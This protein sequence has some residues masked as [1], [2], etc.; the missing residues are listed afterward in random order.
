MRV[1]YAT[2]RYYSSYFNPASVCGR[3]CVRACMHTGV[4]VHIYYATPRCY[5][6][7]APNIQG[8]TNKRDITFNFFWNITLLLPFLG[9]IKLPFVVI[10][11]N[12]LQCYVNNYERL[13][14][15]SC[16][17]SSIVPSY[18]IQRQGIDRRYYNYQY[19]VTISRV[20]FPEAI[21]ILTGSTQCQG[22]NGYFCKKNL[23]LFL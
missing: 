9:T 5:S 21:K 20:G 7:W 22:I 19:Y 3:A 13:F 10:M 18:V 11:Y 2:P 1:Y 16:I 8:F 6:T 4:R 17:F 15:T 23:I 12:C 14:T